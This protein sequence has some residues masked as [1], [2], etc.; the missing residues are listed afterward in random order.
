[1]VAVAAADR[2]RVRLS[3]TALRTVRVLQL[4]LYMLP[5]TDLA[6]RSLAQRHRLSQTPPIERV[7]AGASASSCRG[8]NPTAMMKRVFRQHLPPGPNRGGQRPGAN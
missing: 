6:L 3:H 7:N 5:P 4:R 1:M 2:T 8:G